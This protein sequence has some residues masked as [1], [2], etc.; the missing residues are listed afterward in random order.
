MVTTISEKATAATV[1]GS[2]SASD[3]DRSREVFAQLVL[4]AHRWS[5][6]QDPRVRMK[7]PPLNLS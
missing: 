4:L 6:P 1:L 2:S 7:R 5:V 3:M